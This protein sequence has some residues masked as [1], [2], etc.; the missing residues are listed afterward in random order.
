MIWWFHW[1]L[2][3]DCVMKMMLNEHEYDFYN[4]FECYYFEVEWNW[5]VY[6][7]IF[8]CNKFDVEW[9]YIYLIECY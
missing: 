6:L 5:N 2:Q 1:M 3:F 4:I 7:N 9:K 8:E